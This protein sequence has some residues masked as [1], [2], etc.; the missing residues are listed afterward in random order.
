MYFL[1][2]ILCLHI[3]DQPCKGIF[4]PKMTILPLSTHAILNFGVHILGVFPQLYWYF[5]TKS[6][7]V[8]AIHSNKPWN[9]VKPLNQVNT[10]IFKLL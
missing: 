4:H 2:Y 1:G 7:L 10:L 6:C 9:L 8:A 5:D 3:L